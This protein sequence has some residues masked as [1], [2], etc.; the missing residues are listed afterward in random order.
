MD[1][2][3]NCSG[4]CSELEVDYDKKEVRAKAKDCW[5]EHILNRDFGVITH[6]EFEYVKTEWAESDHEDSD[7]RDHLIQLRETMCVS[8]SCEEL[9]DFEPEEER[10]AIM[11]H[12]EVGLKLWYFYYQNSEVKKSSL[13]F[14]NKDAFEARRKLKPLIKYLGSHGL[15][16]RN[17]FVGSEH[18]RI[19]DIVSLG[20]PSSE[21]NDAVL[22][23]QKKENIKHPYICLPK[24]GECTLEIGSQDNVGYVGLVTTRKMNEEEMLPLFEYMKESMP[25]DVY[26]DDGGYGVPAEPHR[27]NHFWP[28]PQGEVY[29]RWHGLDFS[30][31]NGMDYVKVELWEQSRLNECRDEAYWRSEVD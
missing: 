30:F 1:R 14:S 10:L 25:S 13:Y 4:L 5:G 8:G 21:F 12:D 29:M 27:I 15:E 18:L 17:M 6:Y 2:Y 7:S 20:I 16:D 19:G 23:W 22:A 24:F 31:D 28:L 11:R 3:Y 26:Y 9:G